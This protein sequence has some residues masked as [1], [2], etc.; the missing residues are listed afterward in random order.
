MMLRRTLWSRS[1]HCRSMGLACTVLLPDLRVAASADHLKHVGGCIPMVTRDT[2][3]L[4]GTPCWVDLS[5]DS[6]EQASAFYAGLFGWEV[7]INP[8]PEFG[9]HGNFKLDGKDVGGVSPKMDA[10]Q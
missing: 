5:V 10:A 1:H 8:A 6:V 4:P 9:G 7:D 2:A 3:W